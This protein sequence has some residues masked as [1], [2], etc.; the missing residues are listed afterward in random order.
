[1]L[2][3]FGELLQKV[4]DLEFCNQKQRAFIEK[5]NKNL[6][7]IADILA[8]GAQENGVDN[9]DKDELIPPAAITKKMKL[10]VK[11]EKKDVAPEIEEKVNAVPKKDIV[12]GDHYLICPFCGVEQPVTNKTCVKC[13][14]KFTE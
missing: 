8:Q 10:N 12:T 7:T 2:Y 5:M 13:N 14:A 3:F 1:M 6:Q 11:Q 4:D 9:Q